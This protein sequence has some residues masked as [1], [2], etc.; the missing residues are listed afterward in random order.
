M[1]D[2]AVR[3]WVWAALTVQLLGYIY[4]VLWHG[5]LHPG[6][7]P[8]TVGDMASHLGTVHLPLYVGAAA[9]LVTTLRALV[10]RIPRS[11]AGT[12]LPVAVAGAVLSFA[13]EA[14]HAAS[15]L[16]M[17]THSAP[18]AGILSVVGFLLVVGAMGA[19]RWA[20]RQRHAD[21]A[22]QQRGA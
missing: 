5:L 6:V 1:R 21:T 10:H 8:A 11:G 13:A 18:V 12:A 3:R 22:D 4:D 16:R 14:W 2:Q 17:D 9:V 20:R 19:S 7:E 15:H